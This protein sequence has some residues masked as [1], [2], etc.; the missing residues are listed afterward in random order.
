MS[1]TISPFVLAWVVVRSGFIPA[2]TVTLGIG[3][4]AIALIGQPGLSLA[5]LAVVVFIAGCCVVGSRPSVDALS[6]TFYPTYLR[7]AGL[8]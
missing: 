3:V 5:M 8:E 6:A 1:R 7:S 2:L 4:V